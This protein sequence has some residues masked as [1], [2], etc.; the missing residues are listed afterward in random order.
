MVKNCLEC[1]RKLE[2]IVGTRKGIKYDAL[3]CLECGAEIMTLEQAA[4]FLDEA[5]KA[6]T[7]TFSKWGESVAIRIPAQAVRKYG[8]HLKEKGKLLFEKNGFKIIPV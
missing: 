2:K 4:E 8:I 5:Q 3:K 1:G 7:V 6:K